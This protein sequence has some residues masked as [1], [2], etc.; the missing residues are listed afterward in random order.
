LR[1]SIF[2]YCGNPLLDDLNSWETPDVEKN[3]T[4]TEQLEEKTNYRLIS[5]ENQTENDD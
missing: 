3:E 4:Q 5:I 2:S 1:W